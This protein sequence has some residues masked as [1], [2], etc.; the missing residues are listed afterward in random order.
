MQLQV[1]ESGKV[2]FDSEV[3]QESVIIGRG[4]NCDVRC[5]N[6]AIS[7][8]HIEIKQKDGEIFIKNLSKNNWSMF[9]NENLSN[10]EYTQYFDFYPLVLPG[11][12]EIKITTEEEDAKAALLNNA[13]SQRHVIEKNPTGEASTSA[14]PNAPYRPKL[15]SAAKKVKTPYKKKAEFSEMLKMGV[16]V[17]IAAGFLIFQY[18]DIF[19][20]K[21]STPKLA[22]NVQKNI[23]L[24]KQIWE[25]KRKRNSRVKPEVKE[26][27]ATFETVSN[28]IDPLRLKP[29]S[30]A[31]EVELCD[32]LA[33]DFSKIE[34][35]AI[36]GDNLYGFL[37]YTRRKSSKFSSLV[38][39]ALKGIPDKYYYRLL[40]AYYFMQ[41]SV[42]FK[43]RS[44][45]VNNLF[46]YI[47]DDVPMIPSSKAVYKVNFSKNRLTYN[48]VDYKTAI[49]GIMYKS[50]PDFFNNF[51]AKK[52]IKV[53]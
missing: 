40:V 27:K 31:K 38:Y 10:D 29:C 21:S 9:N 15:G 11:E 45:G 4:S 28:K 51:L 49:D 34:G 32:A 2:I 17:L 50:N 6:E 42:Y 7:R 16:F 37:G 20:K 18:K 1:I 35:V 43:I 36:D 12:I 39:P 8:N 14:K 46:V 53:K 23:E 30:K 3:E 26:A 24:N 25:Q 5:I 44:M 22:L 13:N 41:P 19:L 47:L 52:I 48:Q 33:S